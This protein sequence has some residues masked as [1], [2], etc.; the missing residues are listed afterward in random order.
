M[1]GRSEQARCRAR[2]ESDRALED[3]LRGEEKRLKGG[4]KPG[5]TEWKGPFRE[6]RR[7]S[8]ADRVRSRNRAHGHSPSTRRLAAGSMRQPCR[9]WE[10]ALAEEFPKS[11]A[12]CPDARRGFSRGPFAPCVAVDARIPGEKMLRRRLF[13][14]PV[15][16][17][18]SHARGSRRS[19]RRTTRTHERDADF[20]SAAVR[21]EEKMVRRRRGTGSR[22]G[23]VFH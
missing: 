12:V 21:P 23:G 7:G 3:T 1:F 16:S 6:P 4:R 22:R 11:A 8:H 13:S 17:P 10:G 18:R 14:R 19:T 5:R 9:R 20:S 15:V 2:R